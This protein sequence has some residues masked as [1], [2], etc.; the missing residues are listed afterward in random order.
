[1]PHEGPRRSLHNCLINGPLLYH[2]LL[3]DC[4][5]SVHFLWEKKVYLFAYQPHSA[6]PT[7]TDDSF[8]KPHLCYK[9][10]V[11]APLELRPSVAASRGRGG[12]PWLG[13]DSPNLTPVHAAEMGGG[14]GR[15][16][17]LQ[18]GTVGR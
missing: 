13:Q 5:L 4:T 8:I 1:M 15:G 6:I 2:K 3:I 12:S 7:L 18:W 14:G 17:R 11:H 9:L 10:K 16:V